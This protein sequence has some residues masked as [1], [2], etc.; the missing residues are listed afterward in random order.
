M[1]NIRAKRNYKKAG[2]AVSILQKYDLC[3]NFDSELMKKILT[4]A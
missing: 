3:K 1:A 4:P 2:S